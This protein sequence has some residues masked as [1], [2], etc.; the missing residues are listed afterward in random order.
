MPLQASLK[1]RQECLDRWV[2][3]RLIL[4]KALGKKNLSRQ[5][6]QALT[7][8]SKATANRWISKWLEQGMISRVGTGRATLY[9]IE[10]T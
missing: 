6:L 5:E 10:I 8:A 2:H 7:K 9:N 1:L 3:P 4:K